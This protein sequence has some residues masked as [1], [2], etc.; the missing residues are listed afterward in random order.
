MLNK[1]RNKGDSV[2]SEYLVIGPHNEAKKRTFAVVVFQDRFY[3]PT[4]STP[5]IVLILV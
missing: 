3:P 5:V 2:I 4:Y 1:K